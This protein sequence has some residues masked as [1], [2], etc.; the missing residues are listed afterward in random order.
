MEEK[1]KEK[2]TQHEYYMKHMEKHPE[3][4]EKI[5][6]ELCNKEFSRYCQSKHISSKTHQFNLIKKE[7]IPYMDDKDN[8][9]TRREQI[10][11]DF[12]K[13]NLYP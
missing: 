4:R 13:R 5:R 2:K 3:K 10:L 7:V 1:P 8:E 12:I 11:Q 6:C 9:L